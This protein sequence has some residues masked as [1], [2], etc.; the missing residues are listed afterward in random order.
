MAGRQE[1]PSV[2][3]RVVEVFEDDLDGSKADVTLSFALDG[4][5]YEIDLSNANAQR[6]RDVL[7]PFVEAARPVAKAKAPKR[8]GGRSGGESPAVVRQWARANGYEVNERGR[9]PANVIAA[10]NAAHGG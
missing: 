10:Y 7:Q 3:M 9:I 2:V 8:S 5:S 4:T 6:M 1:G